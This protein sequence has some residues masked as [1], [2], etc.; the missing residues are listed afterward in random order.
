MSRPADAS[1]DPSAETRAAG[2]GTPAS[3]LGVTTQG[4]WA[5]AWPTMAT[6]GAGTLVRFTDFSMVGGLGPSA[7]AGVGL[8]GNFYWLLESL[9]TIA[10]TGLAAILARAVGAGDHAEVDAS[11][12]QAQ[13]LGGLLAIVGGICLLPLTVLAIEIYGVEPDV[14]RLGS[15]YLWWRIWGTLPLS[16]V[17]VFGAALRAAGDVRTPLWIVVIASIVNVFFNWVLIYGNLGAPRLGVSGAAIASNISM[18][19][20][21]GLFVWPW[22]AG[23]LVIQRGQAGWRPD[24]RMF[25]RLVRVGLPGGVE[26]GLFQVGLMLFQRIMSPFGTNV[27]AAYNVGSM[28]LSFS[29][30]PG[31]GYSLAA[32][33]LVGQHLGARDPAAAAGA[34]WRSMVGAVVTMSAFGLLL[35]L[36]ARPIAAL[37][38]SDPDV[39]ELTVVAMWIFALAHPFMAIEF[40]VGGALRGAGDTVFP[41]ISVFSGLLIVRLGLALVLVRYFAA[42][43]ELV[44]AVLIADYVLKA[45]MLIARFRG[46]TWQRR[47]V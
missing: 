39:V 3:S 26:S 20:M 1:P 12:R 18:L 47:V 42:G 45:I 21:G 44:W 5:L 41:M 33:T 10:P 16:I 40:A 6:M 36:G 23:R 19:V 15:D 8:G 43:I 17:M 29:F 2:V 37:F 13:L 25:R 31:V 35:A 22:L 32:A 11:F 4:I 27:I 34:G 9:T 28:L 46:G 38:T 7:L 30:I 24:R 14:V